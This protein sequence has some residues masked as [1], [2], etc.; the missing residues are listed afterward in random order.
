MQIKPRRQ[1][2]AKHIARDH[3]NLSRKTPLRDQRP[4]DPIHR[5]FLEHRRRELRM[6]RR[7][8]ARVNPRAA[9]NIQQPP[10]PAAIHRPR[11]RAPEK[12]PA[13]IHRRREPARELVRLHR[14]GPLLF[15]LRAAPIR[16]L[17][18]A[19]HLQQ[20]QAHRPILERPVVRPD[21][22]RRSLHQMLARQRRDLEPAAPLHDKSRR[23]KIRQHH[24]HR[25]L[26]QPQLATNRR[27]I[28]R[29]PRQPRKKIQPHQTCDQQIRGV[30]PIAPPINRGGIKLRSVSQQCG[31]HDSVKF[32]RA[33]IFARGKARGRL[34][35]QLGLRL[36]SNAASDE[37]SQR[38][39]LILNAHWN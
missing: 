21:E 25:P 15:A 30:N 28:R 3:R 31:V 34:P 20:I 36:P 8:R 35:S 38:M 6:I 32:R 10:P 27:D 29:L 37:E 9:A 17:A 16:R 39:K 12:R 11:Q 1:R 5:R 24:I 2:R 23:R 18:R 33:G 14:L 7:E 4:R 26:G 22:P 19:Q 13:T